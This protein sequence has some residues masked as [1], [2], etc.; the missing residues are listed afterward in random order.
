MAFLYIYEVLYE[1]AFYLHPNVNG[2]I[3]HL[4]HRFILKFSFVFIKYLQRFVR[5]N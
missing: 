1:N 3:G 4:I 2:F 5:I